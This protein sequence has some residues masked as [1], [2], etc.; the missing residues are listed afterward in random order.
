MSIY[1]W[2]YLWLF[3]LTAYVFKTVTFPSRVSFLCCHL[4]RYLLKSLNIST[5]CK[6]VKQ[7]QNRK[8][9]GTQS[10]KCIYWNQAYIFPFSTTSDTVLS[11]QYKILH[12]L[13]PTNKYVFTCKLKK[14]KFA[15]FLLKFF[16]NHWAHIL[17]MPYNTTLVITTG[18]FL[19]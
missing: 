3:W 6:N 12:R 17:R 18:D 10:L 8:L 11:F 9:N 4:C 1:I 7:K 15:W 2:L 14:I 5:V 19:K 13:P 16:W